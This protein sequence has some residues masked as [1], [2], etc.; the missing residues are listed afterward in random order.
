MSHIYGTVVP[1]TW[2]SRPI[3]MEHLIRTF[4][5][6]HVNLPLHPSKPHHPHLC[7]L[8]T[9]SH[10]PQGDA[11]RYG[12]L[13]SP[14][15]G[16]ASDEKNM[17]FCSFPGMYYLCHYHE[18]ECLQPIDHRMP[19][20][21]GGGITPYTPTIYHT[22][23]VAVPSGDCHA[24]LVLAHPARKGQIRFQSD[25]YLSDKKTRYKQ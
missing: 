24:L 3:Y 1:Y 23:G 5:L 8:P 9:Q 21:Y 25:S 6:P 12:T 4:S 17:F 15:M 16:G 13:V 7:R 22:Q 10:V 20:L 18:C 11:V 2:N 14:K 19:L